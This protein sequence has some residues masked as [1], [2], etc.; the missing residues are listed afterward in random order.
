LDKARRKVFLD[1]IGQML[2]CH[3]GQLKP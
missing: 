2:Q 1:P 3:S